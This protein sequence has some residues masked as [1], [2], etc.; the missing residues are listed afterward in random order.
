[1]ELPEQSGH[2]GIDSLITAAYA[3][4]RAGNIS[5]A[6]QQAQ[7]ALAQAR[8]NGQAEPLAHTL[9]CLAY[10]HGRLGHHEQARLLAEEALQHAI[11]LSTARARAW[12]TLGDCAHEHG[13]ITT[14]EQNY[15]RAIDLARQLGQTYLL[16]RCL[17]SLAACVY[18]P[19]GQFELS[20]AADNESLELAEHEGFLEE[21]WLPLLTRSWTLWLTGHYEQALTVAQ[22]MARHCPP[23]SLAEGYYCCLRGDLAQDSLDPSTALTWYEQARH[24]AERLGEPGLGTDLR[25]GLCRYHRT[26]GSAATAYQWAQ[27]A[28]QVACQADSFDLQGTALLERGQAAWK[29]GD[30]A[31]ARQDLQTA[32]TLL[33]P[34][35][36]NYYLAQAYLLLAG[37]LYQ[38]RSNEAQATWIEAMNR[39]V[40]GNYGFLFERERSLALP[41]L[42]AYLSSEN[43]SRTDAPGLQAAAH[44]LLTYLKSVSPP[45]LRITTLGQ[46]I[47][48]QEQARVPESAW[49]RRAGE[50]FRLLLISPGR[51][52]LRDQAL[53]V[54]W[55]DS[56]PGTASDLFYR[57]TSALRRALEADLPDKF[58]S[59]YLEV[60]Q[61]NISLL[62]PAGSWV[63][64][65][66]FQNFIKARQWQPAL[67]L[68]QGDL[69]PG[70]LYAD[71]AVGLRETLRQQALQAALELA[72]EF[73]SNDNTTGALAA[74]LQALEIE[75]WQEEAALLAMQMH[76]RNNDRIAAIRLYRQLAR[77]LQDELGIE[78][79]PELKQYY[80]SLL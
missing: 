78:P 24:V 39:I 50:L 75:P 73:L 67:E 71:W 21:L 44:R 37:L 19:R 4:E 59:R 28:Y 29:L 56:P 23:N 12:K 60:S 53:A 9:A 46:F 25:L 6:L 63:D 42:N 47:V 49:Q 27:D 62:L 20:L 64:Y 54:L 31:A 72:R 1:M 34:L 77:S 7:L 55:P 40:T 51:S 76:S 33:L 10:L 8:S 5:H 36:A 66:V 30:L 22:Q 70:D 74:S 41:M 57:A 45:P 2:P 26:F 14:A 15:Q 38:Q 79:R 13:D 16:H 65:Q 17:H 18:I 68:Y 3:A 32:I 43:L 48:R 11:P 69:F 61:G 35:S 80:Q 58:P 52:L